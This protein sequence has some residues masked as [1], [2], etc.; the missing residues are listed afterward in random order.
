MLKLKILM[1]EF[2]PLF[3][4][5]ISHPPS[6]KAILLKLRKISESKFYK[7]SLV[8]VVMSKVKWNKLD[9]LEKDCDLLNVNSIQFCISNYEQSFCWFLFMFL[10]FTLTYI[11]YIQRARY[12]SKCRKCFL[13]EEIVENNFQQDLKIL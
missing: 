3:C 8:S 9:E 4:I 6:T 7:V 5:I 1:W 10:Y 13:L 12:M 11:I 2:L